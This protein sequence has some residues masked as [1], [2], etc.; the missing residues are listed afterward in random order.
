MMNDD[1]KKKKK[2]NFQSLLIFQMMIQVIRLEVL[3]M[4][5]L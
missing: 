4:K 1:I 5:K 3:Y 2:K